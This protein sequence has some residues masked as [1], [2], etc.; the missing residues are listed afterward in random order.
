M[1]PRKHK[2]LNLNLSKDRAN[3]NYKRGRLCLLYLLSVAHAL[4]AAKL[5]YKHKRPR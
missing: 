1:Q 3:L 2:R 5:D 4:L